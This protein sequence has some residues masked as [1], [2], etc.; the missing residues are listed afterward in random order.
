MQLFRYVEQGSITRIRRILAKEELFLV[1]Q[2]AQCGIVAAST[3]QSSTS[4]RIRPGVI[5]VP[6]HY[7]TWDAAG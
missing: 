1:V 2:D 3:F 6:F 7:G 4:C 5:F